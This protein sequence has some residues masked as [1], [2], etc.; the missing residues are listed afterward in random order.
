[1][2]IYAIGDI[3]GQLEMLRDAHARIAADRA[4]VNDPAAPV[5]HVGD[6]VDRGPDSCGVIDHLIDGIERGERWIV[7]AGNHDQMFLTHIDAAQGNMHVG[8]PRLSWL[9]PHLGGRDTLASYGI[10]TGMLARR[11]KILKETR[12]KVPDS[13][14]RFLRRLPLWHETRDLLFVHAGIRPGVPLREQKA[15][16]LVWIRGE[17]LEDFRP[18]PWLVVHGHTPVERPKHYGNRV[19]IDTGAGYGEPLTAVVFEGRDV[20]VL[21]DGG[22]VPLSPGYV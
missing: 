9:D 2:R 16:D 12:E 7:L 5:V 14:H 19:N 1:M 18:H 11:S 6:L 17:F 4:R 20:W 13:H 15:D 3:H 10:G 21:K 22:R 8:M